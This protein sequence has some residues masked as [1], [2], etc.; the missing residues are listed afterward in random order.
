MACEI[1]S[2]DIL[3]L[4]SINSNKKVYAGPGAGKT[5]FLINNIK[6]MFRKDTKIYKSEKKKILC[7]TYTNSA[8]DEIKSRLD[9]YE[10]NIEICT[11]HSFIIEYIIKFYQNE[12]KKIMKD[13]Y[14]IEIKGNKK[15]SSQI[16]GVGILHGQ[17]KQQIF[18]YINNNLGTNEKINYSKKIMGE[19]KVDIEKYI[20]EDK[21][22]LKCSDKIDEIHRKI[23]KK[24]L[25]DVIRKLN[26]DEILYFGYRILERNPT[27]LYAIRAQFPY[28]FVDEFQDT[29]PL[30]TKMLLKICEKIS[31]ITIIGDIAQSIYSFQGA[32]PTQFTTFFLPDMKEYEIKGNRRSTC[33]IVHMCNYIRRN[34]NLE[35]VSIKEYEN[36]EERQKSELKLVHFV[37]NSCNEKIESILKEVLNSQGAILTRTWVY[38][39]NYIMNIS[40]AQKDILK[41]IYS[42]YYASPID[43]RY[44]IVESSSIL[45]VKAFKFIILL[46]EVYKTRT[47]NNVLNAINIYGKIDKKIFEK[48]FSVNIIIKLNRFLDDLFKD[49][50]NNSKVIEI[51][52]DFNKKIS[53]DDNKE[54]KNF[55]NNISNIED[56]KIEVF[57]EED[58]QAFINLINEVEWNT[59]YTLF[60][61]VFSK[62]SKYMTVHQAKGLE[63]KKVFVSITAAKGDSTSFAE[64]FKNSNIVSETSSDEF[65][66]IFY[67][68][69]SRAIEELYIAIDDVDKPII[70]QKLDEYIKEKDI[71]KFYD[72]L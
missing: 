11:I 51:I 9:G 19:V 23:I 26:H 40:D 58:K 55:L 50:N 43:I 7:I 10:D 56:F 33:N 60:K 57:S 52:I 53:E 44:E 48:N 41:N 42:S 16:E 8:V 62:D 69:C 17:D 54:I 29:N 59:A 1:K 45:W 18:E 20:T 64:M 38:A 5:Y 28:I 66:R 72:F 70:Q 32:R 65:T 37:S 39:F 13:D 24:Y 31:K 27:I 30:Q 2:G 34:D 46:N 71:N 68:A 15:I 22:E 3:D 14:G 25:W 67:V 61:D 21:K 4:K 49:I 35:Q 36:D 47:I 12:L 63:W 6:D